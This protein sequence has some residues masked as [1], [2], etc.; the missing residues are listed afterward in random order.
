MIDI[1]SG[2]RHDSR[3]KHSHGKSHIENFGDKTLMLKS[4]NSVGE[5]ADSNN[6]SHGWVVQ[7]YIIRI[8]PPCKS[9]TA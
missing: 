8:G 3:D 6:K 5:S 2:R 7:R 9:E 4:H 1:R